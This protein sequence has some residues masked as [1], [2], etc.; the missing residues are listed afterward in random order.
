[1]ISTDMLMLLVPLLAVLL[2]VS[3]RFSA[4]EREEVMDPSEVPVSQ[5]HPEPC[6]V[7][8]TWRAR[9]LAVDADAHG[10]LCRHG[11]EVLLQSALHQPLLLVRHQCHLLLRGFP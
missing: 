10:Q 1:M 3:W 4:G 6:T 8:P 5:S 7:A 2:E 9:A 11:Q